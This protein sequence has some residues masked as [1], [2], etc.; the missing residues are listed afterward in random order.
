MNTKKTILVVGGTGLQGSNVCKALV[1]QGYK[2][3]AVTRNPTSPKAQHVRALGVELVEADI[4]SADLFANLPMQIDGLFVA[5]DAD[6]RDTEKEF[7]HGMNVIRAAERLAGVHLVYSS[8]ANPDA[9]NGV[10][11]F[12]VKAR[13]EDALR[14]STLR[15]TI[16]RPVSFMETVREKK[17]VPAILWYLWPRVTG[18]DTPLLWVSAIDIARAAVAAFDTPEAAV[19]KVFSLTSDTRSLREVYKLVSAR[20]GKKQRRIPM[21]IWLFKAMVSPDLIN[22]FAWQKR[23]GF[24]I[25]RADLKALVREPL[26]FEAWLKSQ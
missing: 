12:A 10:R 4:G 1:S 18:W 16:L 22:L 9:K 23:V 5:L 25:D 17:Y 15:W 6:M 14:R 19:G 24:S 2:V 8:V 13:L 20:Q 7:R 11:H 21:P 3:L 26:T